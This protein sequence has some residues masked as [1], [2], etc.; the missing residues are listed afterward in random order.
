[1]LRTLTI[2]FLLF[3]FLVIA[4]TNDDW[5]R[6]RRYAS[7][8]GVDSLCPQP[9]AAC[10]KA[11]FTQIV[12]GKPNQRLGYQGLPERLDTLRLSR[13][14]RQFLAGADWCPLLDSLESHD[15]KYR[16]LKAYCMRC[17]IDDYMADSL[18]MEQI[19]STLNFYR[20][21]NRFPD[22]KRVIVNI[23][24]ATLQVIDR[25]G[26][27]LLNSRVIVGKASTPTPS[28]NAQITNIVTY[29]YWN[30]PRSIAVNE[31]LPKIWKNPSV[32]LADMKLQ[33]I[34][35]KGRIVSPESIDWSVLTI[36]T[37]PYRLRQ[38]TG[39]DN[40]LGL[41]KFTI[42]DPYDIYVHD[43]N[44]RTLFASEKRTLSHGCIRVEKPVE[45]ANLL[46]GSPRFSASFLT[47]F[48]KQASPRTIVMPKAVPII[49]AYNILDVDETGAVV[50]YK[51]PYRWWKLPL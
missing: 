4:Q 41:I 13:L 30:V 48:Q 14:T 21:L 37:F 42:N 1:M 51:D 47:S 15:R 10:L 2:L 17:L 3:P 20:W 8:I 33:L 23:P 26:T 32:V 19:R 28:F 18:T 40:A 6:L 25:E 45:L 43:T 24:S 50:V 22:D 5:N 7:D 16:Q 31:L 11:Y 39:C 46:L 44:Q 29:P 49:V 12:Y 35:A 27:T 34:D 38:S 36:K 9:D